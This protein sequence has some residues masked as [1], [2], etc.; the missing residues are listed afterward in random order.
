MRSTRL[1]L[2]ASLPSSGS[3]WIVSK[4]GERM[5]ERTLGWMASVN[6]H[7]R[8]G[9]DL[10]HVRFCR[11]REQKREICCELGITHCVDDLVHV[12]QILRGA[13]PNL[14]LFGPVERARSGPP[15]AKFVSAWA[16]SNSRRTLPRT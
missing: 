15:W 9:I 3:V 10:G 8:T 6:F 16:R 1:S 4:D 14:Y 13:V 12:M 7:S 2:P 5:Q 11:E